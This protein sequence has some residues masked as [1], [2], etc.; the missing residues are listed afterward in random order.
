MQVTFLSAIYYSNAATATVL[1]YLMPLILLVL[2][3]LKQKR[4]PFKK[5][6]IAVILAIIGTILIC[7]HGNFGGLA[8]SPNAIFWGISSAFGM[9]LYTIYA[10]NLLNKYSCF[11]VLGWSSL[12][13]GFLLLL[14][15]N[16]SINKAIFNLSSILLFLIIFIF[17]TLVAY[18]A[19][20]ESTKYISV[21]ETGTLASFEPLSAYFFSIVLLGNKVGLPE[22]IGT[23]CIVTMVIILAKN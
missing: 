7:T 14:L 6:I 13:N 1:Q 4:K 15:T 21:A 22:L 16:V 8:I 5:E 20:L 12:I 19:Y 23:I 10:S 9:A 18:Y 17:G 11:L 3:L 2:V